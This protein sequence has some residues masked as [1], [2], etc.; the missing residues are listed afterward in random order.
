MNSKS[1]RT[2]KALTRRA[3]AATLKAEQVQ[4]RVTLMKR[5]ERGRRLSPEIINHPSKTTLPFS[6]NA[7]RSLI[8]L[9]TSI[10]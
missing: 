3:A 4:R 9:T 2:P 6:M 5:L 1:P 7:I 10:S 8:C